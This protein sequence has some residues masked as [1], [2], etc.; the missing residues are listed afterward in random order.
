M[1]IAVPAHTPQSF[2]WPSLYGTCHVVPIPSPLNC[3]ELHSKR[4]TQVVR[5]LAIIASSYIII[6]YVRTPR[7]SKSHS[8]EAQHSSSPTLQLERWCDGNQN[9]CAVSRVVFGIGHSRLGGLCLGGGETQQIA[10]CRSDIV[11][12]DGPR[13]KRRT[14]KKEQ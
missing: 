10:V 11:R 8:T 14:T 2:T 3:L 12:L 1:A 13:T 9:W 5:G 7:K 4:P 6:Y